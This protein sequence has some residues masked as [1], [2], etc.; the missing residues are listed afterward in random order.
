MPK[1]DPQTTPQKS[2]WIGN[3]EMLAMVDLFIA[4]VN[5]LM[6]SGKSCDEALKLV[7]SHIGEIYCERPVT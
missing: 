1:P 7:R 4:D 3:Q 6:R 5:M 2:V